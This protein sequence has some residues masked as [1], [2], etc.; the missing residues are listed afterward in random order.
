MC[1]DHRRDARFLD[2]L[3]VGLEWRGRRLLSER[4]F[5]QAL[6]PTPA[7]PGYGFMNF[8]LNTGKKRLPDAPESSY[9]H[10]G[11]GTNAVYVDPEADLVVVARW[12][13][14]DALPGFVARARAALRD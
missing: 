2:K 10:L 8:F 13:E 11:N 7:Q 1:D 5:A 9:A 4:F 14:S 3:Q 12:I 6:T